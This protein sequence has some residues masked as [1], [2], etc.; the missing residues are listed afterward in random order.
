MQQKTTAQFVHV[1]SGEELPNE[2]VRNKG[3]AFTAA[4]RRKSDWTGCCMP[5]KGPTGRSSACSR[6]SMRSRAILERHIY[7]IALADQNETLLQALDS[8]PT[9]RRLGSRTSR[10]IRR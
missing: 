9:R 10:R 4:E 5:W 2:P 7:L 1:P 6:T 3:T 8:R